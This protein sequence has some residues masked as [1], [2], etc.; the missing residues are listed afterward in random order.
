MSARRPVC[1]KCIGDMVESG[2]RRLFVRAFPRGS[3]AEKNFTVI[4]ATPALDA[5]GTPYSAEY[6][7]VYHSADSG[8]GQ[9]RHVFLGGNE[10]PA[11]WAGARV[12]TIVE[13]GFGLGLNFLATWEAWRADPARPLRLHFVS[14]EKHP[15]TREDLTAL[16]ERYPEFGPLARELQQSWPL[17][18]PGLRRIELADGAVVLTLAIG[19]AAD[20]LPALRL[21]AD[22]CYLDGF[23]PARNP[24]MWSH[25]VVKSLARLMRADAT[26]ATYSTARPVRDALVAAGFAC[27][28][29]PGFGRKRH[30]LAARYMPRGASRAAGRGWTE[31]SALVIGA[32]LAGAAVA[33]R[34]AAR[35]W[36]VAVIE[37]HSAPATEASGL[38]AG[39]F[40]PLVAADDSLLARLTRAGCLYA[41][42]R[43]QALSAAGHAFDWARCGL[44][45]V[46]RDAREEARMQ[47][48]VAALRLPAAYAQYLPRAVAGERVGRAV[49]AGG[50]WFADGGWVRAASLA[51]AQLAAASARAAGCAFHAGHEVAELLHDG[52]RWRAVAAGGAT[53]AAAPVCVLANAHAATRLA[54]F[55]AQPLKLVRG[56]VTRLPA[57]S[58]GPLAAVLAGAATLAPVS[59]GLVAGA[60]YDLDDEDPAPRAASHA[61][62]LVRL[63]RL[64]PDPPR[65]DPAT[66]TGGVAFR[67]VA[68]DRLPLIGAAPDLAAAQR[69]RGGLAGAQLYRLPRVPGLYAAIAYA[70]R[71]LTWAALGGEMLASLIEGEPLPLEGAL[72][73]AIDPGRFAVRAARRFSR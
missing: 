20:V 70:S 23:A 50:L 71:G 53:I 8:P 35:G 16:H 22:A 19:I 73:D 27:Q 57:G 37:R 49:N 54:A 13:L 26:L 29:R 1:F 38:P 32:G 9:A 10:L 33:E 39:V 65:L 60:S 17:P 59:D 5:A 62:N 47:R 72:A 55:G 64:L 44:L 48:A 40:H 46:A 36:R 7:D 4:P 67:C 12:F 6:G 21:T 28:L 66:L 41:L 24:D 30:M 56:Q 68:R 25:R 51:K 18:L 69:T 61:A 52:E 11:R 63:A 42:S 2:K 3:V 58:C 15:F 31:H 43:W 34:L 45:Q 14:L